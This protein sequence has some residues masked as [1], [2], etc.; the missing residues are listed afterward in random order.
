MAELL[1]YR[2]PA[3]FIDQLPKIERV[4]PNFEDAHHSS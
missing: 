3:D 2:V 1:S 4:F